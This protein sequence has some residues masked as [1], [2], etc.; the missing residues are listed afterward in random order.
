MDEHPVTLAV[1]DELRRSRL[2]VFF[3]L[4]LAIPHLIW[5][6]IWTVGAF[7]AAIV[8]WVL[9]LVRGELPEPLHR[10]F[11]SYIRY[12]VHLAAYVSLVADPYPN[13][14]GVAGS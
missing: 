11:C 8:A 10:F 9:V 3:R 5:F 2:T 4:L 12:T 7:V 14:T 6:G 13:F 1:E